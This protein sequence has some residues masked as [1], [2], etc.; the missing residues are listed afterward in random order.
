MTEDNGRS[1]PSRGATGLLQK[2]SDSEALLVTG[3]SVSAC[4]LLLLI[5]VVSVRRCTP[6]PSAQ[7][8]SAANTPESGEQHE[9]SENTLSRQQRADRD[10][11]NGAKEQPPTQT[12]PRSRNDVL[13]SPDYG[14]RTR[15]ARDLDTISRPAQSLDEIDEEDPFAVYRVIRDNCE[16]SASVLVQLAKYTDNMSAFRSEIQK[17]KRDHLES[18]QYE[19]D[20]AYCSHRIQR[21]LQT[22]AK[23]SVIVAQC[24]TGSDERVKL[25]D[26]ESRL[27]ALP[28][29]RHRR[30][31]ACAEIAVLAWEII[32][33]RMAQARGKHLKQHSVEGKLVQ[34]GGVMTRQRTVFHVYAGLLE[35]G[36]SVLCPAAAA[37]VD[38]LRRDRDAVLAANEGTF[39]SVAAA[40]IS[41]ADT[42]A[43]LAKAM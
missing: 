29:D 26:L 3:L 21:G 7:D 19:Y 20:D 13:T 25:D 2:L 5:L 11:T 16:F 10:E 28:L 41:L 39:R 31:T 36:A 6:L 34:G 27:E 35:A 32:L 42:H 15:L 14:K 9:S 17:A 24:L 38:E 40:T 1:A 12:P 8:E 43:L 37:R 23:L 30:N 33:K 4:V 18:L 22:N